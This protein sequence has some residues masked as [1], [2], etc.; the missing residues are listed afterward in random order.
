MGSLQT[1]LE[2]FEQNNDQ[3]A[4]TVLGHEKTGTSVASLAIVSR[5][6]QLHVQQQRSSSS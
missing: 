1:H 5:L 3:K 4:S 6:P 2:G